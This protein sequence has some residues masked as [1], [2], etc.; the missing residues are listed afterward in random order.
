[1]SFN[2]YHRA[3]IYILEIPG[4]R[5]DIRYKYQE[6]HWPLQLLRYLYKQLVTAETHGQTCS[7]HST[8]CFAKRVTFFYGAAAQRGSW[9]PH[10]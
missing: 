2:S 6:M 10:S 4:N 7:L 5:R 8:Q 3:A 1:M 9:P